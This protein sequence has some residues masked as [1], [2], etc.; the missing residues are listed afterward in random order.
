MFVGSLFYLTV[1]TCCNG[2]LPL[3]DSCTW[4]RYMFCPGIQHVG[5][6][7]NLSRIC[8]LF[9]NCTL[10]APQR[11]VSDAWYAFSQLGS[12]LLH[13][14]LDQL[15]SQNT[16]AHTDMLLYLSFGRACFFTFFFW[17]AP[18]P[19]PPFPVHLKASKKSACGLPRNKCSPLLLG[20]RREVW[21]ANFQ[22]GSGG[23]SPPRKQKGII[24][25]F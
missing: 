14:S 17:V 7:K 20:V 25:F 3:C 10:W 9:K 8:I 19:R 6:L 12:M 5:Y 21:G 4:F 13:L 16:N 24:C 2:G 15:V 18:P 11:L 23:R 22:G 1:V